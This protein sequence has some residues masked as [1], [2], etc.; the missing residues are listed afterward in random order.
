MVETQMF[1]HLQGQNQGKYSRKYRYNLPDMELSSPGMDKPP[2]M[3][4]NK[5]ARGEGQAVYEIQ[6]KC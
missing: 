1:L 5:Q 3:G 6:L 4:V 2:S